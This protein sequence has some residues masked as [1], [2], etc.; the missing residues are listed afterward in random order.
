MAASRSLFELIQEQA[1]LD[2][3][4][5]TPLYLQLQRGLRQALSKGLLQ[6]DEAIPGER[7]L[8]AGLGVSRVTVRKA[9][10]GL[11]EEGLLQQRQGSG[12]FVAIRLEQ[13]LSRLTS[14]SEDISARGLRPSVKWLDRSVGRAT[15]EEA[16]ALNLSPNSEVSRLHRIRNA[17]GKPLAL[18]QATL[19]RRYLPDP[20][21]VEE[22]LYEVLSAREHRPIRA[23]Q[24]LRAELLSEE[25]AVLLDVP[26]GSA[27]LYIERRSFLADG[28]PIEFT[29]SHYRSDAY[30][31]VAEL[32]I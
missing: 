18:E 31:F 5:P 3:D 13:P 4:H 2:S 1:A 23:L 17:D 6:T 11:V 26:L 30:D 25:R 7:E 28:T 10:R 22:S 16:M 20:N 8:A 14:F 19:P 24:R 12:T 15:P 9:V 32:T 27:A 21:Q 29:R